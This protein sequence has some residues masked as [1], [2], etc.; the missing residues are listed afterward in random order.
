MK[1][2]TALFL[3]VG[4]SPA[5]ARP[6]QFFQHHEARPQASTLW[7]DGRLSINAADLQPKKHQKGWA[8]FRA[9]QSSPSLAWLTSPLFIP[10]AESLDMNLV[11]V[12]IDDLAELDQLAPTAHE[13][14]GACGSLEFIPQN[15]RLQSTQ[16]LATPIFSSLASFTEIPSLLDAVDLSK[17]DATIAGLEQLTSRY[18]KHNVG[19]TAPHVIADSWR[20]LASGNSG[21][22]VVERAHHTHAVDVDVDLGREQD[23]LAAAD[24][25]RVDLD[26]R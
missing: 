26:V 15:Y 17:I 24:R 2:A 7:S 9:R 20:R 16:S 8:V 3:L 6:F 23:G 13:E 18:H 1:R 10:V 25:V 11:L 5:F 4:S 21:L 22:T 14:G 19:I 12:P